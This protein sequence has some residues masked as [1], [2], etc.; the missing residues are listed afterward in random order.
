MSDIWSLTFFLRLYNNPLFFISVKF[1]KAL[2]IFGDIVFLRT[3][4]RSLIFHM[5]INLCFHPTIPR[6][7]KREL[8][9]IFKELTTSYRAEIWSHGTVL[10]G[11]SD[12]KI[13]FE[14]FC[15]VRE[16]SVFCRFLEYGTEFFFENLALEWKNYREF[17][18]I[19]I[20]VIW[21]LLGGQITK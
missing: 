19:E 16:I 4:F 17:F 21:H 1:R 20:F 18:E 14:G 7:A 3:F 10:H 11:E 13:K 2:H 9:M 5:F 6:V 8:K 12:K 15:D